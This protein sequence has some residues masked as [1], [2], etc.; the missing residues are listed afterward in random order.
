MDLAVDYLFIVCYTKFER[1]HVKGCHDKIKDL[2]ENFGKCEIGI[3]LWV[4]VL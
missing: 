2:S 1:L 4:F 3:Q